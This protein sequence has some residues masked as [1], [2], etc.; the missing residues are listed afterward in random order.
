MTCVGFLVVYMVTRYGFNDPKVCIFDVLGALTPNIQRLKT[1]GD[2]VNISKT[3]CARNDP[4]KARY[5]TH[6]AGCMSRS[7]NCSNKDRV[8]FNCVQT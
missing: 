3:K 8:F 2:Q 1:V 4:F 7:E 6:E 5:E